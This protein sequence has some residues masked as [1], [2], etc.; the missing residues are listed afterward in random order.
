MC[1]WCLKGQFVSYFH[2]LL[3]SLWNVK[4]ISSQSP[5][6]QSETLKKP[7]VS[8]QQP[9][10]QRVCSYCHGRG[11]Q[12][13][14]TF[15]KLE[16]AIVWEKKYVIKRLS[17]PYANIFFFNLNFDFKSVLQGQCLRSGK[18]ATSGSNAEAIQS[19]QFLRTSPEKRPVVLQPGGN[20]TLVSY[21]SMGHA[22]QN[23]ISFLNWF[24]T[25]QTAS[26]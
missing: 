14:L 11:K 9:K 16:P 4:K 25:S 3:F 5:R 13:I 10:T 17:K 2:D 19:S 1:V 21:A 15:K 6:A 23:I 24:K 8:N 22:T 18:Q 26:I 20:T 7:L 12:Q